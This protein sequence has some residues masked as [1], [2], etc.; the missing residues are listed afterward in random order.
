MAIGFD[1]TEAFHDTTV[2]T[3]RLPLDTDGPS[4]DKFFAVANKVIV[5]GAHATDGALACKT[6]ATLKIDETDADITAS[7]TGASSGLGTITMAF[8]AAAASPAAPAATEF[9]CI[10]VGDDANNGETKVATNPKV[11]SNPSTKYEIWI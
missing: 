11:M 7:V 3:I 5:F 4:D 10:L 2:L 6:D 8:T 1:T 9:G